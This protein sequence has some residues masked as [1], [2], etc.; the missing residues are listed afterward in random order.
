MSKATIVDTELGTPQVILELTVEEAAVVY[1][2]LG[3][4]S[5]SGP[6]RRICSGVRGTLG[7][8]PRVQTWGLEVT[9]ATCK[10][11]YHDMP[12]GYLSIPPEPK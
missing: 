5:E 9:R 8:I 6:F 12:I 11:G 1:T 4:I 7:T 2:V 10:C 3:A